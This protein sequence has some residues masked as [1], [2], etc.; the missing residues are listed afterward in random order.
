MENVR[1]TEKTEVDEVQEVRAE[2]FTPTDPPARWKDLT[3]EQAAEVIIGGLLQKH[4]AILERIEKAASEARQRQSPDAEQ[5]VSE[6]KE[7]LQLSKAKGEL[8][9]LVRFLKG[10]TF[11]EKLAGVAMD[12]LS[13]DDISRSLGPKEGRVY[14]G[15]IGNDLRNDWEQAIFD[16]VEKE[17]GTPEERVLAAYLTGLSNAR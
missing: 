7:R 3:E 2:P 9:P 11:R 5:P 6:S 12:L 14:D 1:D 16:A 17:V 10:C 15:D 8:I 4:P 13:Y